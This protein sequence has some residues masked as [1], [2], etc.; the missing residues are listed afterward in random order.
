[1]P[2]PSPPL[3][4]EYL[5]YRIFTKGVKNFSLLTEYIETD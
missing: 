3:S 1:M 4:T 2:P 5:I